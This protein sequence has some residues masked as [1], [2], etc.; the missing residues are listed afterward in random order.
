MLSR[1]AFLAGEQAILRQLAHRFFQRD[2]AFVEIGILDTHGQEQLRVSRVLA[3][4]DRGLGDRSASE[5]F[6]QGGLRQTSWGSVMITETS[7]PWVTLAVP[8]ECSNAVA[9][10]LVYGIVNLESLWE[11]TANLGLQQ[12]GRAYAVDRT[13]RLIAADDPNLVLKQL[14]FAERPLVQALMH[15]ANARSGAPLQG[16][17]TNEYQIRVMATGLP[18]TRTGWAVVVEQPQS[19]L[20]ASIRR[21]LW[22]A[23]GLSAFGLLVTF[24]L[25]HVSSRRFTAPIMRLREG[26]EQI[27]ELARRFN[28]M[29]DQLRAS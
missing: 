1:P 5:L 7:E 4:T 29:A 9:A 3:I 14:I 11:V 26:V 16:Q 13:G 21:K 2:P 25:A 20:Y 28:Q 8:L 24:G 22:F 17:Y 19:I 12:G 15:H 27:G 18:L 6:Q 10:G 23:V